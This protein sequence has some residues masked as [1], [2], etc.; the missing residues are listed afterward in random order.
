MSRLSS[1]FA[2]T[3]RACN[4]EP[5]SNAVHL[6]MLISSSASF[7]HC[8]AVA[9]GR[10]CCQYR[11]QAAGQVAGGHQLQLW[12]EARD[13]AAARAAARGASSHTPAPVEQSHWVVQDGIEWRVLNYASDGDLGRAAKA[14]LPQRKAVASAS[15]LEELQPKHLA[16]PVPIVPPTRDDHDPPYLFTSETVQKAIALFNSGSARGGS[17]LRPA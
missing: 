3:L 12:R 14:L 15:T 5:E 17:G 6:Q 9:Q 10:K 8:W 1:A 11:P 7:G 4:A 16:A 13:R 2:D